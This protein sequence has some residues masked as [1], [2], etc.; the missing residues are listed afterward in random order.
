MEEFQSKMLQSKEEELSQA[1]SSEMARR[2]QELYEIERRAK[3]QQEEYSLDRIRLEEEQNKR[4]AE[5]QAKQDQAQSSLNGQYLPGED[6]A[7]RTGKFKEY[8]LRP[9]RMS[10]FTDIAE[11][12]FRFAESQ[13]LRLHGSDQ[14][15]VTRVDYIVNPALIAVFEAKQQ[16]LKDSHH[17]HKPILVCDVDPNTHPHDVVRHNFPMARNA[18]AVMPGFRDAG[19]IGRV[20]SSAKCE[21]L[22]RSRCL[23]FAKILPGREY[24]CRD[25]NLM[26]NGLQRNYDSHVSS[27]GTE[28][29]IFDNRQILPCYIVHYLPGEAQ[30]P[31][32]NYD[33]NGLYDDIYFPAPHNPPPKKPIGKPYKPYKPYK[34][35]PFKH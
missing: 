10:E 16:E 32:V 13:F 24:R 9:G 29:A 28:F 17:P 22:N 30:L 33:D 8:D 11:I 6:E 1:M 35:K 34:P 20:F 12:H 18:A 19:H 7:R 25:H 27:S 21:P 4:M 14:F 15:H 3:Q 31:D 5:L 2:E 23:V 26:T